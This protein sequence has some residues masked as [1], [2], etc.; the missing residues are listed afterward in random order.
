MLLFLPSARKHEQVIIFRDGVCEFQFNQVLNIKLDQI[1]EVCKFLKEKLS[2][3]FVLI[4]AQR[5]HHTKFFQ[6]GSFDNVPPG[7]VIDNRVGY[8]RN[9]NFYLCAH[10]GMVSTTRPTHY[11]VL[12]DEAGFSKND[13]RRL[14]ILFLMCTKGALLTYRSL[15]LFAM[16]T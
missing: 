3:K 5:N 10:E 7:T 9:N 4:V 16:P 13:Q 11:H 15:L 6:H 1:I 14:Y 8:P 12:W 2:P